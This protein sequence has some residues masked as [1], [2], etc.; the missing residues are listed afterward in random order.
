MPLW[1][2]SPNRPLGP[3]PK[4]NYLVDDSRARGLTAGH[5]VMRPVDDLHRYEIP[6][7]IAVFVIGLVVVAIRYRLKPKT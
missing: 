1:G 5:L 7:V 2:R 3:I 6:I 4:T